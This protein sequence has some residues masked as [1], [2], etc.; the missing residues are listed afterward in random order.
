MI[1][2][3]WW[4]HPLPTSNSVHEHE[5][6]L[7]MKSIHSPLNVVVLVWFWLVTIVKQ[8]RLIINNVLG[9][10]RSRAGR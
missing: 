1:S 4:S 5:E 3:V 2:R 8:N 6:I 9:G 10:V 7:R